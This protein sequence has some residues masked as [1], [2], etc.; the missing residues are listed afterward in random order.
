MKRVWI[1]MLFVLIIP[2]AVSAGFIGDLIEK[3]NKLPMIFC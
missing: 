2:Q 3:L 1:L